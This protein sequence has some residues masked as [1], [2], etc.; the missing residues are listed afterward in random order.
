MKGLLKV[1]SRMHK[2]IIYLFLLFSLLHVSCKSRATVANHSVEKPKMELI[3][4]GNHS[5]F[6]QEQ[7]LKIKNQEELQSFYGRINRTRKPGLQPPAIDFNE[8]MLLIWCGGNRSYDHAKLVVRPGDNYLSVHKIDAKV[9]KGKEGPVVSP[10]SI[11]KLSK[12]TKK[13][14]FQ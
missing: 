10:F 9:K 11:Y 4:E 1:G 13:I 7:L 6:D 8:H 3:V 2:A 5:G 12:S 14:K